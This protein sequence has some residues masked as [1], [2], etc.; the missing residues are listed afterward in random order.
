MQKILKNTQDKINMRTAEL[1]KD[2]KDTAM[3]KAR[4]HLKQAIFTLENI[5]REMHLKFIREANDDEQQRLIRLIC[6]EEELRE[7]VEPVLNYPE[8]MAIAPKFETQFNKQ[9]RSYIDEIEFCINQDTNNKG[10]WMSCIRVFDA[11]YPYFKSLL[12]STHDLL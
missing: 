9:V 10:R 8:A 7:R 5:H 3:F 11:Y 12:S 6:I 2:D 1:L 4:H